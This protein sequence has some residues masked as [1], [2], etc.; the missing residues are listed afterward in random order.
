[1]GRGKFKNR[2]V[3]DS[4]E[5]SAGGKFFKIYF[6]PNTLKK[7]SSVSSFMNLIFPIHKLIIIKYMCRRDVVKTK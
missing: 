4:I 3:S 7:I 2:F 1:M 6:S 5:T